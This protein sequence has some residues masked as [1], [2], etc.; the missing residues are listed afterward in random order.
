MGERA[1]LWRESSRFAG[2]SQKCADG[3]TSWG[4]PSAT[5]G[6][7]AG[8]SCFTGVVQVDVQVD[9]PVDSRLRG[10]RPSRLP[11]LRWQTYRWKGRT[12]SGGTQPFGIRLAPVWSNLGKVWSQNLAQGAR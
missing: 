4:D 10:R 3:A 2:I 11:R 7:P 8:A 5:A 1:G 12:Q 6:A 9:V